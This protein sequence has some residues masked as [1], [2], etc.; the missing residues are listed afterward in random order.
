MIKSNVKTGSYTTE[1]VNNWNE[2]GLRG[3]HCY[4]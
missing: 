2:N 4:P 1:D 3:V